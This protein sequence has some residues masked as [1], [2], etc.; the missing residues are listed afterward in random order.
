MDS[1]PWNKLPLNVR[2]V[3]VY[4]QFKKKKQQLKNQPFPG[5]KLEVGFVVLKENVSS[6]IC[7]TALFITASFFH[8]RCQLLML[9]QKH[10]MKVMKGSAHQRGIVRF[11]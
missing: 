2:A 5:G 1:R 3:Q 9:V 4:K 11:H 6:N 10:S 8:T 7:F